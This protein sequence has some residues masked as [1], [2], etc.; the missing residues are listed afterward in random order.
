MSAAE[1]EEEGIDVTHLG[2]RFG[3]LDRVRDRY[4]FRFRLGV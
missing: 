4:W 1:V 3:N 2:D